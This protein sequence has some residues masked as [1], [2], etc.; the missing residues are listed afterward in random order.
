MKPGVFGDYPVNLV[1][2]P[3]SKPVLESI[4]RCVSPADRGGR[5]R[6][7]LHRKQCRQ[8]HAD[9][10]L[11]YARAGD[12][13]IIVKRQGASDAGRQGERQQGEKSSLELHSSHGG[14]SLSRAPPAV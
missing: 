4:G 12:D 1:I 11:A 13:K 8:R 10:D 5:Y 6:V 14:Y 9:L 7:A 2:R 3:D